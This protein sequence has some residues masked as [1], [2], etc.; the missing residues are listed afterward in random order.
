M[1]FPDPL[2]YPVTDPEETDAVQIKIVPET[3]PVSEIDV[4]A[5]EQS[6]CEAGAAITIGVGLITSMR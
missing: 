5:P 2:E 1:L 6:D 4:T 3:F